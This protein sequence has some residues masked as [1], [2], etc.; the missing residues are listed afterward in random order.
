M[1][2]AMLLPAHVAGRMPAVREHGW[3]RLVPMVVLV[4]WPMD[5]EA[6]A[7]G[8]PTDWI[9][10]QIRNRQSDELFGW[11]SKR[12]LA[13]R[14]RQNWKRALRGEDE[15]SIV[16]VGRAAQDY[17]GPAST[18]DYLFHPLYGQPYQISPHSGYVERRS[19]NLRRFFAVLIDPDSW[20]ENG[21]DEGQMVDV[22]TLLVV[23]ASPDRVRRI[24]STVELLSDVRSR[25]SVMERDSLTV[26][27]LDSWD[28]DSGAWGWLSPDTLAHDLRR[29]LIDSVSSDA[30]SDNGSDCA[31]LYFFDDR[32]IITGPAD[33]GAR[34]RALAMALHGGDPTRLGPFST[35][36]VPNMKAESVAVWPMRR[37][38]RSWGA[39]SV[40]E[41]AARETS[42]LP[43]NA[44]ADDLA[45]RRSLCF[46]LATRSFEQA[47]ETL[48][49]RRLA[50][51][52]EEV[53]VN[54][55]RIVLFKDV[56]VL[57][58]TRPEL[59]DEV[60]A[61]LREADS[62]PRKDELER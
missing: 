33:V 2:L 38:L 18:D 8:A 37:L 61:A 41:T 59:I 30:W 29:L 27:G 48:K 50:K 39:M 20:P 42:P 58:T 54:D 17:V 35:A 53:W 57:W 36:C 47:L 56:A 13:E 55:A 1:S 28:G 5:V 12:I 24:R 23:S 15:V 22:G 11:M 60:D 62:G 51:I 7:E 32:L 45:S 25:T 14:V 49:A 3:A 6:W 43:E 16:D 52:H 46:M 9:G 4:S 31:A 26:I 44:T 19:L 34:I 10:Q 21:G 40:E